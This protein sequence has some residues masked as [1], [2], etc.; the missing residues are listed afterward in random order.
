MGYVDIN[1]C[2]FSDEK[3]TAI[4]NEIA[5]VEYFVTI[6]G[7]QHLIRYSRLDENDPFFWKNR[8]IFFGLLYN[9][10]WFDDEKQFITIDS[11]KSL[12][13]S[14]SIPQAPE[15]KL[16]A[17]FLKLFS[18]QDEDGQRIDIASDYYDKILWKILYFK[19]LEELNYYAEVLNTRGLIEA[20]FDKT[21]FRP[22]LLESFR[23]TFDGLSYAIKLSE[24]GDKSNKCFI[25]MSFREETVEIRNA[26]KSALDQTG[27]MPLLV[28]EEN[29]DSDRTIND[30]IIANLKR[31]K[32]CI[33]DFTFHSKGVYFESGHAL[34][35][36]KK[37]IYTC[38]SDEFKNAHFDIRPLQHIIYDTP[39][40]LTKKLID[41]IDAWVK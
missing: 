38:R 26:I 34:G 5:A 14:R 10:N 40:E 21:K 41:K 36:N 37:V 22:D 20:R 35:Q 23:I 19:S 4:I 31:C 6:N 24:E 1:T 28:D 25:A 11:L 39:S 18:F 9:D 16:E 3:A 7:K 32:F 29:I 8:N 27:F 2:I 13:N 33:A 30:E 12:L 15:D 17:L